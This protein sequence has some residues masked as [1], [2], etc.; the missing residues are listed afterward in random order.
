MYWLVLQR[1][2]SVFCE[3]TKVNN[4]SSHFRHH[5]ETRLLYPLSPKTILLNQ[6][7]V[8]LENFKIKRWRS[9][10]PWWIILVLQ[11]RPRHSISWKDTDSFIWFS[12]GEEEFYKITYQTKYQIY[13]YKITRE[14]LIVWMKIKQNIQ[15]EE[16]DT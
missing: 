11:A 14:F 9:K 13:F 5:F 16:F 6:V 4:W 7:S 15:L 12:N 3:Y 8:F 2:N 1:R 10:P